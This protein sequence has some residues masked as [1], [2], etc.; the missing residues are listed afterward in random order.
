MHSVSFLV[1]NAESPFSSKAYWFCESKEGKFELCQSEE[2]IFERL[3]WSLRVRVNFCGQIIPGPSCFKQSLGN[4]AN[5]LLSKQRCQSKLSVSSLSN[6][7]LNM[8]FIASECKQSFIPSHLAKKKQGRNSR[9][10]CW[11]VD[12]SC[13]KI[14]IELVIYCA[15]PSSEL[16]VDHRECKA[17]HFPSSYWRCHFPVSDYSIYFALHIING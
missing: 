16:H 17:W 1:L 9:L 4:F 10:A 8:C 13:F 12:S 5:S 6:V 14:S 7:L 2:G 15:S 11:T 3:L